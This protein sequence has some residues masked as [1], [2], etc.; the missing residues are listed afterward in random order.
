[1]GLGD[2]I[3]CVRFLTLDRDARFT[4]A[5]DVIFVA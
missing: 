1:M 5:L 4:G 3:G 2:R